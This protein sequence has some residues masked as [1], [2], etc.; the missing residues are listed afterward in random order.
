MT[1]ARV[2]RAVVAVIVSPPPPAVRSPDHHDRLDIV[3][4]TMWR[5]ARRGRVATSVPSADVAVPGPARRRTV[6]RRRRRPAGHRLFTDQ[7]YCL[8]DEPLSAAVVGALRFRRRRRRLSA[9]ADSVRTR[10]RAQR[11]PA[12]PGPRIVR[13]PSSSGAPSRAASTHIAVKA[14]T[15]V[16]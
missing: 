1:R 4:R 11:L 3:H 16:V 8:R 7:R 6:H 2:R 9:T 14:I 13:S 5:R 12:H 10:T 15:M